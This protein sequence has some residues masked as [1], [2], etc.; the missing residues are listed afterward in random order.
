MPELPDITVYLEALDRLIARRVL[1]RVRIA[2][3]FV[4]RTAVPP[5]ESLQGKRVVELQRLGKR[6]V[7]GFEGDRWLV[8]GDLE[9][10]GQIRSIA[11]SVARENGRYTGSTTLRQS[12]FAITP[13][14]IAGGAVKVK[15]EIAV[16]F[17]I[18]M[19]DR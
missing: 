18:V 17:A 3:M 11:V 15:D 19:A 8:H 6:V 5:I 12:D 2:D 1:E 7:I 9:L 14:S 10:H 4:L 16:E 13:I